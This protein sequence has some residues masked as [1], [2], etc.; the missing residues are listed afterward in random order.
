MLKLGRKGRD[1]VD[2]RDFK[3]GLTQEALQLVDA[4][5]VF[6]GRENFPEITNFIKEQQ[7]QDCVFNTMAGSSEY[8][9]LQ[10]LK[11]LRKNP[12]QFGMKVEPISRLFLYYN[13]RVIDGDV[14]QDAGSF[15][16]T[17]VMT[18]RKYG[19]CRESVWEYGTAHLYTKPS[20]AAYQEAADH[21]VPTGYRVNHRD[22]E[23]I[24][25]SVCLGYP[26]PFGADLYSSFSHIGSNGKVSVPDINKEDILGG[27]AMWV[28]GYNDDLKIAIVMNSWG[29][30]FGDQ[31]FC[32]FPYEYL[33][34]DLCSDFWSV[35]LE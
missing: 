18:L 23:E 34:G 20:D 1:P 25:K 9:Q 26:V 21:Q 32:Y 5:A 11:K 24:K 4:P 14:E 15:L 30:S 12:F 27:H 22:I 35:R 8:L 29:K 10:L 31:G 33:C 3:F 17:G 13:G 19:I 6:D 2:H 16:R 7:F 28:I